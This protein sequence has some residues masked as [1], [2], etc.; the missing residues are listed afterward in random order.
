[1]M[2][3]VKPDTRSAVECGARVRGIWDSW[4][5]PLDNSG[6]GIVAAADLSSPD[7][8]SPYP[9]SSYLGLFSCAHGGSSLERLHEKTQLVAG[10]MVIVRSVCRDC[11][12][13]LN[14]RNGNGSSFIINFTEKK[15][16]LIITATLLEGNLPHDHAAVDVASSLLVFV[17]MDDIQRNS[18][19]TRRRLEYPPP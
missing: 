13:C 1:M 8:A 18:T 6:E 15:L 4:R 14:A 17:I 9:A 10:M 12:N 16:A 7:D 3:T 5:D 11:A 2:T 19:K